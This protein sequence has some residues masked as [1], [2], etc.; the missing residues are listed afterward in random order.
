MSNPNVVLV[1]A[2]HGIL[3]MSGYADVIVLYRVL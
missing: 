1:W 3:G 2:L